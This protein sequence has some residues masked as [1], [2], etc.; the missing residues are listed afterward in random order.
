MKLIEYYVRLY[1]IALG[2]TAFAVLLAYCAKPDILSSFPKIIAMM[3]IGSIPSFTVNG[4]L[5]R[6][7][8]ASKV[9]WVRRIFCVSFGIVCYM[10]T[11]KLLGLLERHD[12]VAKFA[13]YV[14]AVIV[15]GIAASVVVFVIADRREKKLIS[16]I[17][18]KLS[19]NK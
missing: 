13:V 15:S 16:K 8:L 19:E 10:I 9:L 5:I 17:N 1:F 6:R 14:A 18:E 7:G 4:L 3:A 12:T 11:A 2:M